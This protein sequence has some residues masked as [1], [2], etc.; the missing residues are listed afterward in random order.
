[1]VY[2][3]PCNKITQ[4][5]RPVIPKGI[6]KEVVNAYTAAIAVLVIRPEIRGLP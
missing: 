3:N 4:V 5:S 6:G 2:K 1:M